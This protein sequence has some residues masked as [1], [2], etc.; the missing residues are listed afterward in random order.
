MRR[1]RVGL[2]EKHSAPSPL[3]QLIFAVLISVLFLHNVA[4][5][6]NVPSESAVKAAFLFHFAQFT[7]W[8]TN[9]FKDAATP[10]TFCTLGADPFQGEL[11]RSLSG[12]TIGKRP[13]RVVHVTRIAEAQDCQIIFAG[14]DERKQIPALLAS[15]KELPVLTVGETE[16]FVRDGGMIG[17]YLEANK[18]RFDV[19]LRS[20]EDVKLKISA[21][22]LALARMV[23]GVAPGN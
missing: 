13:V 23:I 5:Q 17:V 12:E 11:D 4:A 14:A 15:L 8:P 22:L 7:E 18:M 16:S 20:A 6:D 1:C 3:G 9:T 2:P 10:L 21:K 19:N